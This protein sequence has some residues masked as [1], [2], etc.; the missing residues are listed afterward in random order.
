MRY[1]PDPST[2]E[3]RPISNTGFRRHLRTPVILCF[4]GGGLL[5]PTIGMLPADCYLR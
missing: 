2:K 5:I 4:F 1:G 3:R